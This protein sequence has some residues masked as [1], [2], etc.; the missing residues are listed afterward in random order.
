MDARALRKYGGIGLM[1]LGGVVLGDAFTDSVNIFSLE[2]LAPVAIASGVA[3]GVALQ[4]PDKEDVEEGEAAAPRTARKQID[5]DARKP[6]DLV[7][8]DSGAIAPA[9]SRDA[10][11]AETPAT[12]SE[13]GGK[14][15]AVALATAVLV[16]LCLVGVQRIQPDLV[17]TL[18]ASTSR[19]VAS[20][21]KTVG[22]QA[23]SAAANAAPLA[24]QIKVA[25][26]GAAAALWVGTL[27]T[28]SS[29]YAASLPFIAAAK[30]NA[31]AFAIASAQSAAAVWTAIVTAASAAYGYMS[32][33]LLAAAKVN[34]LAVAAT[35]TQALSA[36]SSA[37]VSTAT[38]T[39]AATG[40]WLSAMQVRMLA[41]AAAA[42]ETAVA[43]WASVAASS[44]P[45]FAA[46]KAKALA[47]T[48]HP[49]RQLQLHGLPWL[50]RPHHCSLRRS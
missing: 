17:V 40:P 9:A 6:L 4:G 25:T 26:S 14:P 13:S 47:V 21:G 42:F 34:A 29:A 20:F 36:V 5:I 16:A 22:L 39:Y 24:T 32:G 18:A 43:T 33:P 35:I 38:S 2:T 1:G 44:G 41:L 50:R 3:A 27:A 45:L 10:V 12:P 8:D 31:L 11:S 7:S 28:A 19:L 49:W 15:R 46:S 23:G 37:S 48:V 30:S